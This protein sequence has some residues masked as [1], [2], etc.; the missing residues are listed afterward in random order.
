[1]K[2]C[3]RCKV[4]KSETE[5]F[6]DDYNTDGLSYFCQ[7][8][9]LEYSKV[10]AE[11]R[12][13]FVNV[14]TNTVIVK[15][16]NELEREYFAARAERLAARA[17]NREERPTVIKNYLKEYRKAN[18]EKI[19]AYLK[20]TAD[21]RAARR[22]EYYAA[23]AGKIQ[24]VAKEYRKANAEKVANYSNEYNKKRCKTNVLYALKYRVRCLISNSVRNGGY[25]KKS[26]AAEILG[27]SF[28][29]FKIYIEA[30]FIDGMNWDNRELW[31]LDHYYPLARATSEDEALKLNHYTNL[32]PMWAVDNIRK[33]AKIPDKPYKPLVVL[34][35]VG[36]FTVSMQPNEQVT[37]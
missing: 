15:T 28:E 10:Y 11:A 17:K 25:T 36:R 37:L 19:A 12:A 34:C 24:L 22:K 3:S 9:S 26:K 29:D 2:T 21:K 33:G 1:M 30:Q 13:L 23:N 5:F 14:S 18:A 27:C 6:K 16:R 4:E 35:N 7:C 8:C 32:R 31:H 20:T